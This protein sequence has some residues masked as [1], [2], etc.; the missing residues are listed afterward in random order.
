MKRIL[1]PFGALLVLIVIVNA[2]QTNGFD[3]IVALGTIMIITA[4]VI[5]FMIIN[6]KPTS[7]P[8]LS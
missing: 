8:D 7:S 1:I 2:I 5:T 6:S 4:M 3:L